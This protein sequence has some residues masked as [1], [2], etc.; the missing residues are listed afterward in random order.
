[1][2]KENWK[3]VKVLILGLGQYPKGSG[4]SAALFFAKA[5]A[6]VLVTDQKTQEDLAGNVAQLKKFKNVTF[7]MG[8][9]DLKD[10]A[11]ADLVV[12]NPR[13]R[14]SSPEMKEAARLGK[15]IESDV[16]LFMDRCPCP[17]VGVTGT[18]GKSTTTTLVAEM[19]KASKKTV[20]I[21]GNITISPLTFLSKVKAD[22]I[23]VLEL[24]SWLLETTGAADLSPQYSLIT[25]LMRDHLNT[26]EGMD[27]YAEAKA[28]IF[29]H[30][31][32]NGVVVLNASDDYGRE[33]MKEAPGRV[34]S[35]GTKSS[36]AMLT[37]TDLTWK[38]PRTGK[39]EVLVARKQIKLLGEHNAMNI[40]AAA[41]LARAAGASTSAI[42]S[43][44]KSFKGIP[45]RL[46]EIA[47]IEGVRFVND[48]TSTTPDATIAAVK[49]LA[50]VSKT[51]HLIAGGADKE[52]E[53]DELAKLLK[54]NKVHV[55]VF[56]GTAFAPFAKALRKAKV[57]F[58]RVGSMKEAM[59]VHLA[60]TNK[61]DTVLLSPGCASFGIFKNEFERG[62]QF[63]QCV[64]TMG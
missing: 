55:T 40:L 38:D 47:M 52:L 51:I 36:D 25:N 35:F 16:S 48:T 54:K 34:L 22:N 23:V 28:Q 32:G 43:V 33:W 39:E 9:H 44:A 13:V 53:F 42:R 20:W 60:M 49:A 31:D 45:D 29:R 11:W 12:R 1:M 57:A 21:G 46:E 2:K 8:G 58:E 14:P 63:K 19:L 41:L 30:Q 4:V 62:E 5:G 59:D 6:D 17:V 50:P 56:E 64:G 10:I 26:Y 18:R 37:K 24:S 3:N 15:R 27:D 61:G 7:H